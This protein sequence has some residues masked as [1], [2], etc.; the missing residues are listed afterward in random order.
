MKYILPA[1]VFLFS[2]ASYATDENLVTPVE[3][4]LG[5]VILSGGT[6]LVLEHIVIHIETPFYRVLSKDMYDEYSLVDDNHGRFTINSD[7]GEVYFTEEADFE[8]SEEH[9]FTVRATNDDGLSNSQKVRVIVINLPENAPVITSPLEI[10]IDENIGDDQ[11]VY[12]ITSDAEGEGIHY[13]FGGD[14]DNLFSFHDDRRSGK[15]FLIEN[16][17]YETKSVYNVSIIAYNTYALKV[18]ETPLT[19]YVNDLPEQRFNGSRFPT[20]QSAHST[21]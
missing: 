14:D 7:T 6:A 5:P 20:Q 21:R 3:G 19:I 15:A 10:W 18:S 12:T 1:F 9:F 13:W 17:D 2:I 11:L 16:P 8:E 4:E